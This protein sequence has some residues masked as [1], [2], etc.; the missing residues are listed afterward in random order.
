MFELSGVRVIGIIMYYIPVR[1]ER[2][3][4]ETEEYER[5]Q[6]GSVQHKLLTVSVVADLPAELEDFTE[7]TGRLDK[8]KFSYS[9]GEKQI[10]EKLIDLSLIDGANKRLCK[11]Y[12]PEDTWNMDKSA[13]VT[14]TKQAQG[15]VKKSEES[16]CVFRESAD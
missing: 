9:I 5:F 3:V 8:W 6:G 12:Q 4:V 16:N 10:E 15:R 11:G 7:S 14:A 1:K 13:C 2:K